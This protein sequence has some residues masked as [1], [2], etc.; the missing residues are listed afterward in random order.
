MW[1][2]LKVVKKPKDQTLLKRIAVMAVI[3]VLVCGAVS[4]FLFWNELHMNARL[5]RLKYWITGGEKSH[6]AYSFDAHNSNC[7]AGFD[8]GLAVASVSGLSTYAPDGKLVFLSQGHMALPQIQSTDQ[9]VMAYDAGGNTLLAVQKNAGEVL[10]I[11]TEKPILDAD[12]TENGQICYLTSEGGY[13]SVLSVYNKKQELVYRWLSTSTFFSLCAVSETGKEMAA[14]G[15]DQKNGSFSSTLNFF[16]TDS[17]QIVGTVHL[18]SA[19]IY[20]LM[21]VDADTLCTIGENGVHYYSADGEEVK[22]YNYDGGYLKD[23]DNS[24][25]GFLALSLNTYRAGNRYSLVVMDDA[26][27]D[28]VSVYIGQEILDLSAAGKYIAVLTSRGLTVYDRNLSV[29][30]QTENT[31]GATAVLMRRDGTA[32]LLGGGTGTLY[33]P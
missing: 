17:D 6:S 5:L 23:F 15:L 24:G 16:R 26:M 3:A 33:I 22:T 19:L 28:P 30:S 32:L 2:K 14:I 4:L 20:D 18:G 1:N 27:D 8:D 21:Y 7:Y 31:G 13:K 11:E 25:N 12:I 10:R 9:M 29:C